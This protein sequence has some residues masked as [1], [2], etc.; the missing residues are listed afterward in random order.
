MRLGF[1]GIFLAAALAGFANA[2]QNAERV[3]IPLGSANAILVVDAALDRV[4]GRIDGIPAVHG[5]AATPDGRLLIAGS[6]DERRPDGTLPPRPAGVSEDAHA[7]HHAAGKATAAAAGS[8]I[9]TVSVISAMD[10]SVVRRIDVPGAVHHV[11]VGPGGRFAVLTHPNQN[12]VSVL[13]LEN[14]TV[15]ATIPTGTLPNYAVFSPDSRT[16]YVSN[17]GDDQ[18]SAIGA[19]D[20]KIRRNYRVGASPEHLI[21]SSDGRTLYVNNVDDGTVSVVDLQ[22]GDVT[23]VYSVGDSPHGI[24]LSS[25][26]RTLFVSVM[27]EDK[28]VA[29]DLSSGQSRQAGLSPSPYHLASIKGLGK[30]YVS[31]AEE[32]KLWVVDPQS[33]KVIAEVAIGGKG[34]Q[35]VQ[36][37]GS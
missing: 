19:E 28:L 13:D 18:I 21:V 7:M 20:W 2:A 3:Y 37:G 30:L 26:D 33:L 5:L 6:Y 10:R 36:T 17:A 23:T 9:S 1:F 15:L 29:I 4:E 14:F 24:D 22:I 32:P 8:V 12:T 25:D 27:G 34:H 35:M 11:A 31:S 16:I